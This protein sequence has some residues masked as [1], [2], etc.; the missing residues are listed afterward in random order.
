MA[1][2]TTNYGLR[3]PATT[4]FITVGTD[5]NDSMDTIDSNLKRVD[6]AATDPSRCKVTQSNGNPT[7][8]TNA[9]WTT[10]TFASGIEDFDTAA[11]HD[12]S[13]NT[14]RLTIPSTGDYRVSGK[15][16]AVQN[17][18]GS[19]GTRWTKNGTPVAGTEVMVAAAPDA[20]SGTPAATTVISCVAGDIIRLQGYQ[21]SGGAINT[22]VGA[23]DTHP[24]TYAE[25]IKVSAT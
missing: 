18:T 25:I 20:P 1:T 13:T 4:D 24:H 21:S 19:R 5:I 11:F 6:N 16:S 2:T 3:K 9:D 12:N 17:A 23:G 8:L 10:I 22:F 15:V 14:D 7:S